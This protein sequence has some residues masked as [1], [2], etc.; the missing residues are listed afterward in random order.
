MGYKESELKAEL[1]A[2]LRVCCGATD[3]ALVLI[4]Q[5]LTALKR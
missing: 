2:E 3:D 1:E 4:H 5:A